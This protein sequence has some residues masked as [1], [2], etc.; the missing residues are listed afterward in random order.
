MIELFHISDL[1]ICQSRANDIRVCNLLD[2]LEFK[3][4]LSEAEN[5]Y[6]LITGDIVQH[7]TIK[8]Y[9]SALTRLRRFKGKLLLIPGNHE[10]GF[11]GTGY[12]EKAAMHFD[13]EFHRELVGNFEFRN[14]L[15]LVKEI[16]D[17]SGNS[18]LFIGLNSCRLTK[19]ILDFATGEIGE[20]QLNELNKILIKYQDKKFYKLVALH[21]VPHRTGRPGPI[22]TLIDRGAFMDIVKDRIDVLAFG[23]EGKD[24]IDPNNGELP[25]TGNISQQVRPMKVMSANHFGIKYYLDANN[26]VN[27]RS[28]YRI[29][30]NNQNIFTRLVKL[31]D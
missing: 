26:S 11:Q 2:I 22:M 13:E 29:E 3:Y 31:Q 19:S 30:V 8:Q 24:L 23:H 18:I 9:K 25:F 12:T 4:F 20:Q 21:H 6:L 10:Y 14:K 15:P 28:C 17:D 1:H 27:N 5:R 16:K 7:G